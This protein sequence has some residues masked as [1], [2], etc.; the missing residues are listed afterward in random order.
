VRYAILSDIHGNEPALRAVLADVRQVGV[1][2]YVCLGDLVGYGADPAAVVDLLIG[3][4][5]MAVAGNHD[6]ASAGL[7]DLDW[8]NPFARAAA[9]WTA[10]QLRSEQVRYLAALPLVREEAGATLVHASP[11]DPGEWTYLVSPRDGARVFPAF[12]TPLCFVGHSHMPASWVCGEDRRVEFAP[13]PARLSLRPGRRYV[14]NVGSVGQPR[15]GDP[16]AA[17]AVWDLEAASV[18]VR[19]VGYDADEARRRIHAAGLPAILGDRL[20]RGR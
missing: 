8:F 20:L 18:E 13:G 11:L 6:H 7:M 2:R 4:D 5:V 12:A 16:A 1:D 17:Y 9:E 14:V 10:A 19:R 3:C 15:D